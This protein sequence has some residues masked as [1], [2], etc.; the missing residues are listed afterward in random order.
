MI[1]EA[2]RTI[3]RTSP[4]RFTMP[5]AGNPACC[6]FKQKAKAKALKN[7][8]SDEFSTCGVRLD[9]DNYVEDCYGREQ[10]DS[11]REGYNDNTGIYR[12]TDVPGLTEVS[13]G[14]ILDMEMD[15]ESY[16]RDICYCNIRESRIIRWGFKI[17]GIYP[18]ITTILKGEISK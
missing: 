10:V 9:P 7:G 2:K 15:F 5:S 13:R 18:A 12:M 8:M 3:R 6:E 1:I 17:E 16:V 14:D 4:M 11:D